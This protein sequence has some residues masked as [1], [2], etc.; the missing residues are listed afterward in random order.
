MADSSAA[1]GGGGGPEEGEGTSPKDAVGYWP[2]WHEKLRN[3]FRRAKNAKAN[4][5]LVSPLFADPDWL[6]LDGAETEVI[7]EA[8]RRRH[9]QAESRA[10]SA[11]GRAQRITQTA[12][13]LLAIAFAVAGFIATRL[14]E[15]NGPIWAWLVALAAPLGAI[16][17]L[18]ITIVQAVGVDR[19]GY[20]GP[21]DPG[22]AAVYVDDCDQ[23]RNLA[24]QEARAALMANWSA[25]RKVNEFL[26][27][28]A[29]LTRSLVAL[30]AGGI[31]ASLVWLLV[32]TPKEQPVV[33]VIVVPAGPGTIEPTT[34]TTT[35]S[36]TTTVAD[37]A[38]AT[39]A[40]T[41]SGNP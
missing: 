22:E 24:G 3:D 41:T 2:P 40:T 35:T 31:A 5:G 26:Q 16:V 6:S 8:A 32:D 23:R 38:P 20:V 37:P 33:K 7:L 19:V 21:P 14:H 25:R 36:T 18:S 34:T 1:A 30:A 4:D 17:M 12:L 15:A 9:E 10:T 13:P 39:G 11:E 29:W 27:A 28:R